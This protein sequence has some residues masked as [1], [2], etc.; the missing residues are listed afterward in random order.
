[1]IKNFTKYFLTLAFLISFYPTYAIEITKKVN[2]EGCVGLFLKIIKKDSEYITYKNLPEAL[3][4]NLQTVYSNKLKHDGLLKYFRDFFAALVSKEVV[5]EN[6]SRPLSHIKPS[7]L[8]T[9]VITEKEIRFAMSSRGTLAIRNL[10]SKHAMLAGSDKV[11]YAGEAWLENGVLVINHGSGTFK[12]NADYLSDVALYF[13]KTFQ[14][15]KVIFSDVLPAESKGIISE[16]GK[17]LKSYLMSKITTLE[18]FF[19][20][21]IA[22]DEYL[23]K[24]FGLNLKGERGEDLVIEVSDFI[25]SGFFGVVHKI[26]IVSMSEE[27]KLKYKKLIVGDIYRDDLVVKFPHNVPL[28]NKFPEANIFDRTI[29]KENDEII[30]L[31][32]II[33]EFEQN[34]ADILTS[35]TDVKP[36]LIKQLVKAESIQSLSKL[37]TKLSKEQEVALK[38]DIFDMAIAVSKKMNLDL[39]IKAENIAW[40]AVNKKFVMYELSIKAKT[41]GFYI[42][43]GFEGYLNYVNQ[44]LLYHASHRKPSSDQFEIDL[45]KDSLI[46]IPAEFKKIY[47]FEFLEGN[48]DL[49]NNRIELSTNEIKGCFKVESITYMGLETILNLSVLNESDSKNKVEFTIHQKT[50]KDQLVQSGRFVLF[51]NDKPIGFSLL[52]HG[53]EL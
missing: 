39:D 46:K 25:G 43:D 41:T 20:S 16:Y 10:A 51:K 18:E 52:T 5:E 22:R 30:E 24:R 12:P 6:V 9:F 1:V 40:D 48:F 33:E 44:R 32:S 2:N 37:G 53:K 38:R 31:K 8:Y 3:P 26:K 13:Q 36:F 28:L 7:Q 45:C 17:K 35:G 29:L 50:E 47:R 15:E 42:K 49:K 4:P 23:G 19:V 21:L 34:A 14:V 11:H 27:A